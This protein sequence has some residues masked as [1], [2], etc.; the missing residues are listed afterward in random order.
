MYHDLLFFGC[1]D[2]AKPSKCLIISTILGQISRALAA[3]LLSSIQQVLQKL[4]GKFH[5]AIYSFVN[6]PSGRRI[7]KKF[8]NCMQKTI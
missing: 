6:V 3:N 4:R 7:F 5:R 2:G 1:L 8:P